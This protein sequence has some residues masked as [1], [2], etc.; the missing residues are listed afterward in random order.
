MTPN[1]VRVGSALGRTE[2]TICRRRYGVNEVN[3]SWWNA[4]HA[5]VEIS[6]LSSVTFPVFVPFVNHFS[7]MLL[8]SLLLLFL[9]SPSAVLG[10]D[11]YRTCYYPDKTRALDHTPCSDDEQTACCSSDHICMAN[12][13]CMNAGRVQPYGFSRA[14]CTD[15]EWGTGCPQVCTSGEPSPAFV[16]PQVS[17]RNRLNIALVTLMQNRTIVT[18][19]AQLYLLRP[20]ETTPLTVATRLRRTEVLPSVPTRKILSNSQAV[21]PSKGAHTSRT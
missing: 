20:T 14:A 18:V 3:T 16:I 8:T 4:P 2:Y 15:L 10:A 9:L 19:D 11:N 12:G 1:R 6:H 5:Q 13:L 7:K 17:G 21:R